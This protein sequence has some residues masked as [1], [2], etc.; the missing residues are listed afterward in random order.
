MK[1][2]RMKK[3]LPM[4]GAAM[5]SAGFAVAVA[6]AAQA[7]PCD[8]PSDFNACSACIQANFNQTSV[9]VAAGAAPQQP[10]LF[11]ECDGYALPTERALCNDRRLIGG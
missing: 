1:K 10:S 5:L 3:A 6:P 4:V 9:C 8:A 2:S 7:G 11:P